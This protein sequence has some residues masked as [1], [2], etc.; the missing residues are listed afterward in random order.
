M[1]AEFVWPER[2]DLS[3][4]RHSALAFPDHA[5]SRKELII[6]QDPP[7]IVDDQKLQSPGQDGVT[8]G[9]QHL[10]MERHD[11]VQTAGARR[12]AKS[13][14]VVPDVLFVGSPDPLLQF[15]IASGLPA[16]DEVLAVWHPKRRYGVPPALL[17]GFIP[18]GNVSIGYRLCVEHRFLA[19]FQF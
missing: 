10:P 11:V 4:N 19:N 7:F 3:S 6:D 16:F 13:V 8:V 17:V 5:L 14:A 9:G 1:G 15:L 12:C 2:D 18:Y